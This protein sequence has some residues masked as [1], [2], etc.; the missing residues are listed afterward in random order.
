MFLTPTSQCIDECVTIPG[1]Y[2]TTENGKKVC[3]KCGVANCET[4]NEQG[5]CSV[6]KDGFYG[7]SC[8]KCHESCKNCGG[9]TA[10]D[11]TEC[12]SG[13]ALKYDTTGNKGTCGDGCTPATGTEAGSCKT[14]DLTVGGT[15]YC[16]ACNV[17]TEYPQNGVCTS[18]TARATNGCKDGTVTGGVCKSCSDGFFLMDGGC[19]ETGKYPGKSVCT[20]APTGGTC[21]SLASGYYLNSGTLVTCGAGCAECTNSDSCTT[22]ASGYVKLTSA[23]TCTKCDAG[24][25]TCTTA[26]STCSTCADG[27]YLSNSKCIA[28]DKSDGSIAGVKDCLSCAAPSGSTGPVLC[29]LVKDGTAGGSDPNLSS[30]AIAGISVAVIV[31]VGGLVGFL[32]WW[33]IC[34]GKA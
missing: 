29:Y 8:S 19:Y 12:P 3:K 32:C 18:K 2:G 23:A 5:K 24:C 14:C 7:E 33:F 11:C 27:Y 4:C 31:I 1:Y 15:K 16:S 10:E 26:A 22:C 13:K 9:A 28:C 25:A 30:G 21:T 34:R 17:A 6:C 20:S